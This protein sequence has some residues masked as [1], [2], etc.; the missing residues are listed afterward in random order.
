MQTQKAQV[1]PQES[2][3][4]RCHHPLQLEVQWPSQPE[5]SSA[6][7]EPVMCTSRQ[8]AANHACGQKANQNLGHDPIILRFHINSR[9]VRFLF[10]R[11][12]VIGDILP[13]V[14]VVR[15][16]QFRAARHQQ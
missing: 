8:N 3:C 5:C 10:G 12:E 2:Q 9:L 16:I 11:G 15:D 1:R 13:R 14:A 6:R 4:W 7:P